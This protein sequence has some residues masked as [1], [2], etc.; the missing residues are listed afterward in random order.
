MA[1]F[2]VDDLT[3][4]PPDLLLMR[5][6]P[7]VLFWRPEVLRSAIESLRTIGYRVVE[8]D[9]ASWATEDDLHDDLAARLDFPDYYGRNFHAL[10]DCLSDIATYDYAAEPAD[11]GFAIALHGF[12]AYAGRAPDSAW[13]L[14]E[15][16]AETARHGLL[17]GHRMLFLL[18]VDDPRFTMRPVGAMEVGWN[19]QEW[20][21][22]NRGL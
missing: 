4:H 3:R 20:L 21:N 12:G 10:T 16:F 5:N 19:P 7:V 11:T 17:F 1:A 15:I 2:D 13:F 18:Q 22:S 14:A 8:L 9:A 6:G